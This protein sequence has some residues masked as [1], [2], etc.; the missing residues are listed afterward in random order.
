MSNVNDKS[1]EFVHNCDAL[2]DSAPILQFKNSGKHP[3][4]CVTFTLA[5]FKSVL[6]RSYSG[7]HLENGKNSEYGHVSRSAACNFL[8]VHLRFLICTNGTTFPKASQL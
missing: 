7:L 8:G 3:W 1:L 6:L 2:H 4:R 5:L